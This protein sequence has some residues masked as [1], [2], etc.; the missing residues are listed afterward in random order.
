MDRLLKKVYISP[1]MILYIIMLSIGFIYF[2]VSEMDIAEWL[3]SSKYIGLYSNSIFF[4]FMIKRANL[5]KSISQSMRIRLKDEGYT[6]FLIK[7]LLINIAIYFILTYGI[8]IPYMF[9]TVNLYLLILYLI[10]MLVTQFI[11]E[12]LM[13][14]VIYFNKTSYIFLIILLSYSLVQFIILANI[15]S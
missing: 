4:I 11:N 6:I 1:T 2:F 3:Y 5:F 7:S 10:I 15:M 14:I 9:H 13:L 12:C 8:F